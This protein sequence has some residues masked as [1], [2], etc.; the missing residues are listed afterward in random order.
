VC[1]PAD[2][3]P[4]CAAAPPVPTG[5]P[6]FDQQT[7][8]TAMERSLGYV[9]IPV[10]LKWAPHRQEGI[11]LGAGPSFGVVTGATDR[12]DVVSPDGMGY[13]VERDIDG[14]IPGLDM[15]FSVDIEWRFRLLS[16]AARYTHGLTDMRQDGTA[17]P[18]HTRTL[19]G[20]GRIYLGKK[21]PS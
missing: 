11:R 3:K 7:A 20:T 16:I 4:R 1:D 14:Q 6:A 13:V 21:P 5:D 10:L 19:T 18:I 8:G 9:E 17:D 2:R 12:Y 15:G